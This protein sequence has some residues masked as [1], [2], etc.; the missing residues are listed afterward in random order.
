MFLSFINNIYIWKSYQ[1]I[2]TAAAHFETFSLFAPLVNSHGNKPAHR[3][4]AHPNPI[5]KSYKPIS[6]EY[7]ASIAN[8]VDY[9]FDSREWLR[10]YLVWIKKQMFLRVQFFPRSNRLQNVTDPCNLSDWLL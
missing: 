6:T 3:L 4:E 5:T 10:T 1:S 2:N 8:S 7:N 9:M